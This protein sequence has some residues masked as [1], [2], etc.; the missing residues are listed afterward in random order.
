MKIK[1]RLLLLLVPAVIS[2]AAALAVV[3]G[4]TS[5]PKW[6]I[7]GSE[8]SGTE[9]YAGVAEPGTMTAAGVTTK[10]EH[11]YYDAKIFNN[12]GA[13]KGEVTYLPLYECSASGNNCT[14][15]K[16]EPKKLPWSLH[17]VFVESKP[18][19]VIEGVSIEVS[20]SGFGCPLWGTHEVTG[21]LGG[22]VENSTQKV[23]FNKASQEATG[24]SLKSWPYTVEVSGTYT[25]ESVGP[26]HRGQVTEAR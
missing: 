24:S 18:Y 9:T 25:A 13:G 16:I 21:S 22:A 17:T 10:C 23:V 1:K 14:L 11:S 15:T 19:I 3:A 20:Y 7:N 2:L 6:Y 8:L 5:N 4:A 12:A 26:E